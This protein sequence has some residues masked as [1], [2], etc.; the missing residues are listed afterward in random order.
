MTTLGVAAALLLVGAVL[1]TLIRPRLRRSRRPGPRTVAELVELRSSRSEGGVSAGAAS[2]ASDPDAAGGWVA[3]SR[4]GLVSEAGPVDSDDSTGPLA[5][6]ESAAGP[7]GETVAS[8]VEA[9]VGSDANTSGEPVDQGPMAP[10]EQA[11][12][13]EAEPD[14]TI[15]PVVEPVELVSPEVESARPAIGPLP[16][17]VLG[18]QVPVERVEIGSVVWIEDSP[19]GIF[20]VVPMPVPIPA[21]ETFARP[22]AEPAHLPTV[23]ELIPAPNP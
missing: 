15:F 17:P 6:I 9:T 2:P 23:A 20:P 5:V 3:G 1:F 11:D 12:S 21:M 14:T 22:V 13:S 16:L 18:D 7:A 19:A 4:P 10:A 8:V